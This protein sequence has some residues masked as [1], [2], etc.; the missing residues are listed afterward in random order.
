M[1]DDKT[2]NW[3]DFKTYVRHVLSDTEFAAKPQIAARDTVLVP[4]GWDRW[5]KIKALD[6]TFKCEQ[7]SSLDDKDSIFSK[8]VEAYKRW[9]PPPKSQTI[10]ETRIDA[11]D[12]QEFLQKCQEILSSQKVESSGPELDSVESETVA[13]KPISTGDLGD[14]SARLKQL[15]SRSSSSTSLTNSNFYQKM[16]SMKTPSHGSLSAARPVSRPTKPPST[17]KPDA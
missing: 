6:A 1:A 12:D 11:Q 4:I 3:T 8:A 15:S 9:L 7:W 17:P 10:L 2:S 13:S 14:V 5:G 16:L